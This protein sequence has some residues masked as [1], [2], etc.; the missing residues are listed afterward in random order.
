MIPLSERTVF[1]S[2]QESKWFGLTPDEWL[3]EIIAIH[4]DPDHGSRYWLDKEKE[5]RIKALDE[6]RTLDDLHVLGPMCEDDLR[7]YPIEHFIPKAFLHQKRDFILGET[8]GTTGRPKVTAYREDDFFTTFVDWF[9]YIAQ[10]RGFPTGGNWLWIGPSGPHIIGKAVR[11]VAQRMGSM[12][13]FSIDFDPRWAKK[14]MPGTIG[15]TR[16]LEHILEQSLDIIE[17]QKVDV[18]YT[19]PVVLKALSVRMKEEQ[20]RSIKGVHYGGVSIEKDIFRK[21]KEEYFPNSVHISGYGNTLFGLC[22]E[23]E[24][25]ATYDLEYYPPG[26]RMVVQVVSTEGGTVPSYTR[27]AKI[28]DYGEVGQVVFHRFDESFFIPNMFERDKAVRIA[29]TPTVR[30]YGVMQDGVKNPSLLN[31]NDSVVKTGL[32]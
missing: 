10:R 6:I 7:K 1:P 21:F 26:A 17:T 25:S 12:D 23:I 20:R 9:G 3:P 14:L 16:Y 2:F 19:T 8:A 28:V 30:E 18:L 15:S 5:L 31:S 4:F 13:P 27:L 22:L 11:P 32:Y 24:E 29:P